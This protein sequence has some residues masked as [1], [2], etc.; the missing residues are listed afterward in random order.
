MI[1][2]AARHSP[3]FQ[4]PSTRDQRDGRHRRRTGRELPP[5]TLYPAPAAGF[6]LTPCPGRPDRGSPQAIVAA[7]NETESFFYMAEICR[8]FPPM[9]RKKS[10]NSPG[11]CGM[12][13]YGLDL[14]VILF[15]WVG[16][17]S[18]RQH[19]EPVFIDIS[20]HFQQTTVIICI[21]TTYGRSH[22][23]NSIQESGQP[24]ESPRSNV[25]GIRDHLHRLHV[26]HGL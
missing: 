11:V 19:P 20:S 5:A 2:S 26:Q 13:G 21:N 25:A 18:L 15:T 8:K 3:C 12:V 6:T 10:G 7:P 17:S 4:Q 14:F 23:E 22:D 9:S 24:Q 1:F 16:Q